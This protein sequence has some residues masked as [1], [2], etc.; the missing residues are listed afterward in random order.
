MSREVRRRLRKKLR[1]AEFTEYGF[2]VQYRVRTGLTR[3]AVD[4]LLDRFILEAIEANELSCGGGGGPSEW[5]FF[6]CANGRRSA[7]DVHRRRVDEWLRGQKDIAVR[8]ISAL[9]DAWNGPDEPSD[10][11]EWKAP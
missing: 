9:H 11:G 6:V 8:R 4:D 1:W 7:T 5:D 3:A 2:A 10:L